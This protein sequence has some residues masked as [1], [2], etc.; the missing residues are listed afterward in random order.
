M[1]NILISQCC[2]YTNFPHD[3][4]ELHHKMLDT[5]LSA[6]CADVVSPTGKQPGGDYPP[7]HGVRHRITAEIFRCVNE[8]LKDTLYKGRLRRPAR[9][10]PAI[11]PGDPQ[12]CGS[13]ARVAGSSLPA[14]SIRPLSHGCAVPALP[15]GEPRGG[16][17]ARRT[18]ISA[19]SFGGTVCV[20]AVRPYMKKTI[21]SPL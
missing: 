1:A 4:A 5:A 2:K 18:E 11:E 14:G 7:L 21:D 20:G 10:P 16:C 13:T 15:Q 9:P 8:V 6:Q 19:W 12:R 17:A 3:T